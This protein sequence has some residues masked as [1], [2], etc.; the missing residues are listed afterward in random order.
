M[1][2]RCILIGS[3]GVGGGLI[4]YPVLGFIPASLPVA[5]QWPS[6]ELGGSPDA[7]RVA[8]SGSVTCRVVGSFRRLVLA[9]EVESF[10]SFRSLAPAGE[11]EPAGVGVGGRGRMRS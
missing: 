5:G 1:R 11:V 7:G 10:G 6:P 8:R 3:L 2:A 4:H 9:G